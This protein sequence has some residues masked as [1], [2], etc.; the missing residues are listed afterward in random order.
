[1]PVNHPVKFPFFRL[2]S[3]AIVLLMSALCTSAN[4]QVKPEASIGLLLGFPQGE[5]RDHVPNLG[6][7]ISGMVGI[8]IPN[9]PVFIGG[10]LG[11]LIYGHEQR[12]EMFSYSIQDVEVRIIT[13]N[14]IVQGNLF[15]R[16]QPGMGSVRP[17]FD[18]LVGFKYLF[19]E[20]EIRNV[21]WSDENPIAESI[22]LGDLA[23]GYGVGFGI[24]FQVV[25]RTQARLKSGEGPIGILI[26]LRLRY[27]MGTEAD[28]LKKGSVLRED[29]GSIIYNIHT[30]RTDF[31][32]PFIGVSLIF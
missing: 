1:M 26:D 3:V 30:S 20:T 2:R 22:N 25:D 4:A 10:D 29:D 11:F 18:G 21:F 23:F 8:R 19:T 16:L 24:A 17:Y 7:G 13:S 32:M 31:L 5:F 9:S 28:Y 27:L 15:L 12:R 14:N 6:I